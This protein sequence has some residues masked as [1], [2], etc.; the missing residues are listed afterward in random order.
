[1]ARRGS[2]RLKT[3]ERKAHPADSD[4]GD[5]DCRQREKRS[6]DFNLP[7]FESPQLRFVFSPR[8]VC[9]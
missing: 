7:H 5:G 2:G 1:M 6:D 3:Q 4:Y 9:T 8:P